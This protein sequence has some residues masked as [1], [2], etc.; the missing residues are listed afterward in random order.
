MAAKGA[1]IVNAL[2][3]VGLLGMDGIDLWKGAAGAKFNTVGVAAAIITVVILVLNTPLIIVA[4]QWVQ[5][6]LTDGSETNVLSLEELVGIELA[7]EARPG[8]AD[9]LLAARG[10]DRQR[11]SELRGSVASDDGLRAEFA[12]IRARLER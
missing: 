2:V 9:D 10:L 5:G 8:D 12:E 3:A 11:W 1:L 6:V 4:T 7:L